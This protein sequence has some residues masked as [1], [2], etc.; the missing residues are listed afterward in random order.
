MSRV[1]ASDG[2]L[3]ADLA[4]ERRIYLPISAIPEVAPLFPES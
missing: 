4:T 1:F 2:Q 3:L